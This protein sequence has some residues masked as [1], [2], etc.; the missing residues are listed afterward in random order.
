MKDIN[1][2]ITKSVLNC[3]K[4]EMKERIMIEDLYNCFLKLKNIKK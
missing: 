4:Y 3:I 1:K 2:K